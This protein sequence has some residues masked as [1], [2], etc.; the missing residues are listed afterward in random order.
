MR[1]AVLTTA[2]VTAAVFPAPGRVTGDLGSHDPSMIRTSSGYVVYS[3]HNRIEAR[4]SP[5]RIAFSRAGSALSAVPSWV[6]QFSS[7]GDVWAP[8]V[9]FHNGTYWLYYAAS[10][11]GSNNSAIGLA[12]SSTGRPG[13]FVDRGIVISSR[14][15][16]N[17]NAIDPGLL[18][19]RQGRWWLAFG[20]FWTGIYAIRLDPA[21][22]KQ[23]STDRTR[24]HLATRPNAPFAVEA[25]YIIEHGGFYYLFVSFDLCCR[26]TSSTYR[27]MVGR[28]T[29]PTGPYTDRAGVSMLNGGGNELLATH[30]NVIGP[31]GQSVLHDTDG[32]LLVYHYYNR[33][34]NGAPTLGVN[35][36][37]WDAQGWPFL[38]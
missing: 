33:T 8:D 35:L 38:R 11:F 32:D 31:G 28:S 34:T 26:G 17:F 20:S 13:T 2:L 7:S 23:S 15:S 27:V 6:F 10:S 18:V 24:Y 25:P 5:D 29:N 12:T 21:T 3:T 37:A 1:A 4:T 16:D 30:D 19:D 22:G 36:I 9:S 14:S